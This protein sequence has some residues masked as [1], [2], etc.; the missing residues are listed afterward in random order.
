MR[1]SS[2]GRST[3][4]TT[5]VSVRRDHSKSEINQSEHSLEGSR[6]IG[7][8][9]NVSP[10]NVSVDYE[11]E[12]EDHHRYRPLVS[13][14]SS[15]LSHSNNRDFGLSDVLL[16]IDKPSPSALGRKFLTPSTTETYYDSG[17]LNL[18]EVV[19]RQMLGER[20][21]RE[22]SSG[23][24]ELAELIKA[25]VKDRSH[26]EAQTVGSLLATIPAILEQNGLSLS[27]DL[28]GLQASVEH[29]LEEGMDKL[30]SKLSEQLSKSLAPLKGRISSI[31]IGRAPTLL[32]SHW[33]R[34]PEC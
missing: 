1:L 9:L 30:G 13:Q 8:D 16:G 23:E 31:L 20:V 19:R 32:R 33:S 10:G 24:T 29:S 27:S 4:F 14:L 18:D 12:I 5:S 34:A 28:H 26:L 6:P 7:A 2:S 3:S 22:A 25:S 15:L 17:G 11:E 21:R